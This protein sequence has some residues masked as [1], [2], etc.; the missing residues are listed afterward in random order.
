M[1]AEGIGRTVIW[2]AIVIIIIIILAVVVLKLLAYLVI[3]PYA[4]G[5]SEQEQEEVDSV[6]RT[7]NDTEITVTCTSN[8][9]DLV[10][11]N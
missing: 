10:S 8:I 3:A 4:F 9:P 11:C 7:I 1:S 5:E 2:A 6:T